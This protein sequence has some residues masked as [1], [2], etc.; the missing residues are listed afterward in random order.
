MNRY[1]AEKA[2]KNGA[3]VGFI[4]GGLSLARFLLSIYRNPGA[5]LGLSHGLSRAFGIVFILLECQ[6]LLLFQPQQFLD[7]L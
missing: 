7:A 6:Y 5:T 3:V 4:A 2:T 1:E